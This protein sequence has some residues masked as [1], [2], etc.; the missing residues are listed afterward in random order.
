MRTL[1]LGLLLAFTAS[2][3]CAQTFP[4]R[5]I[6]LIVP[7]AA[8]GPIDLLSR[9]IAAKLT[10]TIGQSVVV[11]NRAGAGGSLAAE[12][13]ARSAPD[14][15][16]IML[17]TVGTQTINP[18]LFAKVGY[19]PLKDFT[20]ITTIGGYALVLVANPNLE[21]RALSDLIALARA[22]P[23]TINFGSGGVGSSSHLAG[24]LFKST[25]GLQM[26]HVPYK[27]SAAALTDVIAG[28]LAFLFDVVST[29]QPQIRAGKVRALAWSGVKRSLLIPEVPTMAEAALPGFEITGWVGIGAPAGLPKQVLDRLH[30]ALARAIA[31]PDLRDALIAQGYDISVIA[32]DAFAALVRGDVVKWGK[33][34]RDTGAKAE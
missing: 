17:I 4:S 3:V 8:G 13:T 1:I 6:R 33:V 10:E 7:F 19:D 11:E 12:H 15:H 29:A 28:N 14:G 27:G 26:Q 34:V 25:A 31:A 2:S 21:A 16:T 23:G 20:Y 24:E 9:T 32:P 30:E 5:P 22:R 18:A